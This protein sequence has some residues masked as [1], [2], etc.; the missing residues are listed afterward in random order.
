MS[1]LN[2]TFRLKVIIDS[3]S[4]PTVLWLNSPLSLLAADSSQC[5]E[6]RSSSLSISCLQ[7]DTFWR[8]KCDLRQMWKITQSCRARGSPDQIWVLPHPEGWKVQHS[9]SVLSAP[10]QPELIFN[11]LLRSGKLAQ[12]QPLRLTCPAIKSDCFMDAKVTRSTIPRR[13]SAL[14]ASAGI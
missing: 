11:A 8:R 12:A 3:S 14:K 4:A 5:P 9:S 2:A 7:P 10:S 6:G 1:E 13:G